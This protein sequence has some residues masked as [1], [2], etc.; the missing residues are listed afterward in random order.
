MYEVRR[1]L[2]F[3]AVAALP[4]AAPGAGFRKILAEST[5]FVRFLYQNYGSSGISGL[6]NQYRDGLRCEAGV[7]AAFGTSLVQVEGR[8]QTEILGQNALLAAWKQVRP[9]IFL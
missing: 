8:W 1:S 4:Q 2:S 7:Q 6:L 5:S 9:Y 3:H